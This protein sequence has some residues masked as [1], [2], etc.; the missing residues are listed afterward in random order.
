MTAEVAITQPVKTAEAAAG[1]IRA[2][3][4][5]FK[6]KQS[7]LGDALGLT[8]TQAGRKLNMVTPFTL[9]ELD[10]LAEWFSTTPQVLMGF[11]TEPKPV[12]P[13]GLEPWTHGLKVHCSTN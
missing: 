9:D 7:D 11:A 13:Q 1:E 12:R 4:G 6:I 8:R 3:M 2:I 5:R 10:V